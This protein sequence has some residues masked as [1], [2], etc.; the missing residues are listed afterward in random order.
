MTSLTLSTIFIIKEEG[1]KCT[2]RYRAGV[3][4]FRIH[5]ILDF[6]G[7]IPG[8]IHNYIMVPQ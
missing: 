2:H 8:N 1:G 7:E 3:I 5:S 4:C 6:T